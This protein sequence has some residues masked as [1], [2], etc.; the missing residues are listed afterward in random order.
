MPYWHLVSM[1]IVLVGSSLDA[2]YQLAT[3]DGCKFQLEI[4]YAQPSE[5]C[6]EVTMS[7][8]RINSQQEPILIESLM[9]VELRCLAAALS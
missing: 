4:E 5:K 1:T 2:E 6:I 9:Y 7:F 3:N 8:L